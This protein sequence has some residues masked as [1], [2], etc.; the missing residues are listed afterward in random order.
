[1]PNS[2]KHFKYFTYHIVKDNSQ[3]T[4]KNIGMTGSAS[5]YL[6][7]LR[8]KRP[9]PNKETIRFQDIWGELSGLRLFISQSFGALDIEGDFSHDPKGKAEPS[10]S[11][12]VMRD[13][14]CMPSKQGRLISHSPRFMYK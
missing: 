9:L 3:T 6:S 5:L 14:K 7:F 8:N 10:Y 12:N 11:P 4:H 2:L 1:M 13:S